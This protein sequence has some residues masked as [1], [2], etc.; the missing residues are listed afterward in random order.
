MFL[1]R[2]VIEN[3]IILLDGICNQ[4]PPFVMPHRYQ[5]IDAED[6][7]KNKPEI[8]GVEGHKQLLLFWQLNKRFLI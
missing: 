6:E 8:E 5:P 3:Q 7:R 1:N 2:L 4:Y